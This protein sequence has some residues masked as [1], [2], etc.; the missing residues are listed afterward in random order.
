MNLEQPAS[1]PGVAA[2]ELVAPASP[3]LWRSQLNA[4]YVSRALM[5]RL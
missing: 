4:W 3:S 1:V 5:C 2:D